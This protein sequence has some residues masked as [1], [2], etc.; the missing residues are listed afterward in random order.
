MS[1]VHIPIMYHTDAYDP[2]GIWTAHPGEWYDLRSAE[3]IFIPVGTSAMV[4]LGV[5]M[6]L[7]AGYEAILAPR[8]STFKRYG[9][10]QTNGIGVIDNSYCGA[11]DI[12]KMPVF[13]LVGTSPGGSGSMI[14]KGDRIGQFR[15]QQIQPPAILYPVQH[16]IGQDRGGFG[17]TGIN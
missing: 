9:I 11:S 8:S 1:A 12:W 13:C 4:D 16:L 3:D 17:S 15:I 2:D 14:H 5:S 6:Q 7:P 10:I